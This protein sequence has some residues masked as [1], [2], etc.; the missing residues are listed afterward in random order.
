MNNLK[1]NRFSGKL[2]T[3]GYEGKDIEE[4]FS[5]LLVNNISMLCDV[6]KNPVSR[7]PGFSKKALASSCIN[8][9]IE[10]AHH[11]EFGINSIL[12]KDLHTEQDYHNLFSIYK[13]TVLVDTAIQQQRLLE[14]IKEGKTIALLCFEADPLRCHRSRL[15]EAIVSLAERNILIVNL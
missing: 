4:L 5:I 8:N 2:H 12:R 15:A 14:E 11:P 7:K 1:T 3:I 13:Q 9:R 10:Y 6:R